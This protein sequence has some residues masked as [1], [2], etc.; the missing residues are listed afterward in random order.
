MSVVDQICQEYYPQ[1]LT[2]SLTGREVEAMADLRQALADAY[3]AGA[4]AAT[5]RIEELTSLLERAGIKPYR[6]TED[7]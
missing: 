5:D 7:G 2:M 1:I 6:R 4:K 3:C